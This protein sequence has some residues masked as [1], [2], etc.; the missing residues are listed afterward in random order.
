MTNFICKIKDKSGKVYSIV[1]EADDVKS[2]GKSLRD[3]GFYVL[4]I[5]PFRE[6]KGL[7][8]LKKG[9]SLDSLIMFTH[10]LTSMLDSGIPILRAMDVLWKQVDNTNLQIVISQLK[11]K[12]S[13]GVSISDSFNA[14]P[15]IFPALYRAFLSV[16]DTG[17]NLVK[18]LRKLLEYLNRQKE[19]LVKFKK[20]IVYPI[21]VVCLSI[22]VVITMLVWVIPTFQIVFTKIH[23]EL[24]LFTKVIL[25]I[26]SIMRTFY[27]WLFAVLFVLSFFVFYK[28]FS[29]AEKGRDIIDNFKLR[30]PVL[31]K[32]FYTATI[33]TFVRSLSL[34]IAAGVPLVKSIEITAQTTL[35]TKISKALNYVKKKIIEGAPMGVALIETRIFPPFLEEMVSV[36]EE[37]GS[38]EDML[39]RVSTHFEEEFDFRLNRFL[40]LLEPA[41]IIFVGVIVVFILLSI[42][43]P[44][45]KLWGVLSTTG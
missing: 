17:A 4:S 2:L 30:L 20:A 9:V 22:A 10:Q 39:T 43:L 11:N 32:L 7:F 34:L 3:H 18:I 14:F 35:N 19:F 29:A 44:I 38:L 1:S 36:G 21:I 37:G 26:S 23:L 33:A 15:E 45:I 16:A 13:Q 27:F 8:F 24:P 41:L 28:I 40:T 5:R 6:K 42:Y 12:L 25:A 31:G